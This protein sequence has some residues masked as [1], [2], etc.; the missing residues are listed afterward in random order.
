MGK[1]QEMRRQLDHVFAR[2]SLL[3]SKVQGHVVL[4]SQ[5]EVSSRLYVS[6]AFVVVS[7]VKRILVKLLK[8]FLHK[9]ISFD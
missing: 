2:G 5:L 6:T 1:D 9:F 7:S 3:L 8:G 4:V